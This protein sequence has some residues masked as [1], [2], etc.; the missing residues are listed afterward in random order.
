MPCGTVYGFA[1]VF[2]EIEIFYG[3]G[4]CGHRPLQWLH[5]LICRIF[6][7]V[8]V[9]AIIVELLC[10]CHWQATYFDS[11]RSATRPAHKC[12][13]FASVFGKF[14]TLCRAGAH[15]APLHSPRKIVRNRSLSHCLIDATDFQ[16]TTSLR[17]SAHT[18]VAIS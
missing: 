18:G 5:S 8:N 1:S 2:G 10:A 16:I 6:S 4:R 14:V 9:G 15:C 3:K 12:C 11:L 7:I 17:T 13:V